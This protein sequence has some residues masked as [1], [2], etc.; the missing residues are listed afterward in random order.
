MPV[1][2]STLKFGGAFYFSGAVRSRIKRDGERDLGSDMDDLADILSNL[3][4]QL[5]ERGMTLAR[6]GIY[7]D[8]KVRDM[9]QFATL[10]K[11]Y[12]DSFGLKPPVRVCVQPT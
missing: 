1:T 2:Q 8:L 10:N 3:E 7:V 9:A 5:K 4:S 12:I 11:L 6:N